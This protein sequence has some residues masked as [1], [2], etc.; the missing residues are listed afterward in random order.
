MDFSPSLYHL[1]PN[2]SAS[3]SPLSSTKAL[4]LFLSSS[5]YSITSILS[6]SEI[7]P[8]NALIARFSSSLTSSSS[9]LSFFFL[10]A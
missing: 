9:D 6:S 2:F 5:M 8:A 3:L 1:V 10:S 7:S 4:F